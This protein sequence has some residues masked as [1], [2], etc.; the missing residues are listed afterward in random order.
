MV[1][2]ERVRE[3]E[4]MESNKRKERERERERERGRGRA[5]ERE[6][7]REANSLCKAAGWH[8]QK[9]KKK[10]S[11]ERCGDIKERVAADSKKETCGVSRFTQH[12]GAFKKRK[13]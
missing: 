7:E 6:R 4:R 5:G 10:H 11:T 9:K 12:V 2:G 1:G 3:K 8:I 13:Q